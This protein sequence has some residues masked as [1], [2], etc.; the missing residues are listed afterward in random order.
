MVFLEGN[1]AECIVNQVTP[2]SLASRHGQLP[3]L[4]FSEAN[5]ADCRK[6][7]PGLLADHT[8]EAQT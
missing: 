6:V 3:T 4:C 8:H 1:M 2:P 7:G 5:W